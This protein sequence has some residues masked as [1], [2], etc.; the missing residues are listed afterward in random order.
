MLATRRGGG[1][2]TA[3]RREPSP[4]KNPTLHPT[5]SPT[6]RKGLHRRNYQRHRQFLRHG[7]LLLFPLLRS[8]VHEAPPPFRVKAPGTPGRPPTDPKDVLRFLLLKNLQ[9]WSYDETHAT[10]EVLPE[11]RRLLGFRQLPAASTV[12]GLVRKVPIGYLEDLVG[13]L[14]VRLANGPV[15]VAG[16][17]TGLGTCRYQRWID[18]KFRKIGERETFVKLHALIVT[19]AQFPYFL[20]ARL[21]KGN[22]ND[23]PELEPLLEQM[24]EKVE[25]GNTALDKGYQSRKNA[26]LIEAR[27]GFPVIDLK[28]NATT[29]AAGCPA[30]KRMVHRQREDRRAFRCRYR[31][32]TVIEGLFGAWK[33]RFGYRVLAR[34]RHAQ[35]VEALCRVI[36]WN[37]LAV[38][39]HST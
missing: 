2:S 15:S 39:Y 21:T 23:S 31:R 27:G 13:R 19:R 34:R 36:V 37:L 12:V 3:A 8:V 28:S 9:G 18:L 33:A 11:L 30:W 24:P 16:D 6:G 26:Q 22:R 4:N 25:L 1:L 10:L 7:W 17:A 32:R 20:A 38:T 5:R 35:R 14:A 29:R